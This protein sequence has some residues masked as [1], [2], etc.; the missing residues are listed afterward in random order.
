M[1]QFGCKRMK[2]RFAII[3]L[4]VFLLGT[5]VF[6]A[7]TSFDT[8]ITLSYSDQQVRQLEATRKQLMAALPQLTSHADKSEVISA[9]ER[10][11]GESAFEKDGCTWIGWVGLK[12]S[13]EGKIVHASPRW[14]SEV[15][16]PCFPP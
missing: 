11:A 16:D 8:A 5:T 14:S 7:Y 1:I 3:A 2:T 9:L 4:I 10:A 13:Y 12:F 15:R 6:F